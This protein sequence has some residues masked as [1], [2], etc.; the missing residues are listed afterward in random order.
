M[1]FCYTYTSVPY[2]VISEKPPEEEGDGGRCIETH[3]QT[4]CRES[5]NW[6]S[7]LGPS[8]WRLGKT[9]KRGR[10]NCRSQRRWRTSGKQGPLNH[11]VRAQMGSLRLE[12]Q[13]N[14]CARSSAY[15]SCAFV[16]LLTVLPALGTLLL[17]GCLLQ[18][19]SEDFS[20]VLLNLVLSCLAVVVSWKFALF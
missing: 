16:G 7:P 20:L 15:M 8:L 11:L 13:A 18:P 19:Q 9:W 3:S 5:P 1:I 2:P 4:L 17:L 14:L 10:K 6:R 12:Q